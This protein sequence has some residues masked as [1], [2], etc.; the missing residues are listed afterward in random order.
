VSLLIKRKMQER[1]GFCP[2]KGNILVGFNPASGW[3][4]I[5][6]LNSREILEKSK[7]CNRGARQVR[8][9]DRIT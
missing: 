2:D 5:M 9:V 6:K 3:K 4:K 7:K 8:A 1:G